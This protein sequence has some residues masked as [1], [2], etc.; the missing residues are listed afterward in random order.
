MQQVVVCKQKED[1]NFNEKIS[2]VPHILLLTAFSFLVL[3]CLNNVIFE[4]NVVEIRSS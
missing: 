3:F 1:D 2:K 4:C